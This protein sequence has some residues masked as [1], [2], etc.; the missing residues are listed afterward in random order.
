MRTQKTGKDLIFKHLGKALELIHDEKMASK[1]GYSNERYRM[2]AAW[3]DTIDDAR[4]EMAGVLG[5]EYRNPAVDG[6]EI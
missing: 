4:L 1:T 5:W 6:G 2:Y 3:Y